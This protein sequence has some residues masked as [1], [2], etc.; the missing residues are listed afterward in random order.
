MK[1]EVFNKKTGFLHEELCYC[2]S[3]MFLRD[4]I[5]KVYR[6]FFFF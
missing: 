5:Y 3:Q 4:F 6:F 2:D 1:P